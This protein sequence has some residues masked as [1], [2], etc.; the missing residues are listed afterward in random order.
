MHFQKAH[1]LLEPGICLSRALDLE[2]ITIVTACRLR[3]C[4]QELKTTSPNQAPIRGKANRYECTVRVANRYQ[5]AVSAAG[6]S[7]SQLSHQHRRPE[8]GNCGE[9]G[10]RIQDCVLAASLGLEKPAADAP[11][12]AIICPYKDGSQQLNLADNK[13]QTHKTRQLKPGTY[14]STDADMHALLINRR[15]WP[16]AADLAVP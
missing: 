11:S 13:T 14:A 10:P 15:F 3:L 9:E 1:Y 7:I 5:R 6:V 8:F 2:A 12:S 4:Y 16:L